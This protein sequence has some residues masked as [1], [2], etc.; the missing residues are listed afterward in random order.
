MRPYILLLV[1]ISSLGA[2][3]FTPQMPA[4]PSIRVHGESTVSAVPDE[5]EMDIGVVTQAP[6]TDVATSQNSQRS[7]AV[8]QS[9]RAQLPTANVTTVNLSINPNYRYPKEGPPT[10]LGYTATNTVRVRL[11]DITMVRKAIDIATKA[12][13]SS[14]NRL[15]F[16]LRSE[17]DVR[18]RALGEAAKEAEAGAQALAGSLKLK[19]GRVLLVEEGQ[20]VIVSPAPQIDFG[21]AQSTD[22]NPISPGNIQVHANVNLTYE[23]IESGRK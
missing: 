3:S 5:A 15:N 20:P 18:S 19:L 10:I 1:L 17:L 7:G 4:R 16:T 22:M 23:L 13:A 21:K 14:V 12:G 2:Q 6:T 11:D 9:L 8:V